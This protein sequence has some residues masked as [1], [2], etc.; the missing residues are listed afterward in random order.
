[1]KKLFIIFS[2]TMFLSACSEDVFDVSNE[3]AFSF[4]TYYASIPQ[5]NEASNALYSNLLHE[6]M[7]ARDWYFIFDLIGNDAE[8]APPL[9]GDLEQLHNYSYGPTNL[10]LNNLW[11]SMYRFIHRANLVLDAAGRYTAQPGEEADVNRI[12]GEGHFFKGYA[13]AHLAI[14]YGDVPLK[15]DY[16]TGLSELEPTR[17]PV[18][19]V[20]ASAVSDLEEAVSLLP[21]D[22][23]D[24]DFGRITKGA[25]IAMLGKVK[26]WQGDFGG[27]A[28]ELNK[29]TTA[30]YNYSL[31]PDFDNQFSLAN[32]TS[33]ESVFQVM[34]GQWEGWGVGNAFFMFGGQETWGGVA[35]HTG[36]A[37]EYG[38]NDWQNVFISD[39]AVNAFTYA[40]EA[41]ETYVDPRASLTFYGDKGG[42]MTYCD[43]CPDG[44]LDYPFSEKLYRFRKYQTYEQEEQHGIPQS[45]INSQVIRYAD[46]L[47]ML[48]EANI[49]SGNV[50]AALP[51]I[52]EVRARAGA[53]EYSDLGDQANARSIVRH[54]RQLELVGEQVRWFDLV[55]WGI[56]KETL[57]Q[58][59][60]M[61]I[62][63]Q[64]FE[65]K[66][67]LL[68][69]PQSERD[70]N[71]NVSVSNDW[72]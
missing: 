21:V 64:P 69:F 6:G 17:S 58:E 48:A 20:W 4:E 28:A 11:R 13:Q 27:A 12:L 24:N 3:N 7:Y 14:L 57:N 45:H 15:P 34:H 61:Q 59:K 54:E 26:L 65:D 49:E 31:N 60:Q 8:K 2:L 18:T 36:R 67:I 50:N 39:A 35:T 37:Q 66:H 23:G 52:N 32:T 41:G 70:N 62:G 25:A 55:R 47:L 38:W 56:A 29:L 9:L 44:A 16:E 22:Y 5:L 30:P 40:D 42:D 46:V 71:P 1:M 19:A 10:V 51:F 72:N 68:P 43:L 63:D 53:F 33:P